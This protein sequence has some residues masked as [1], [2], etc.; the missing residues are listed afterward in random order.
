MKLRS[1]KLECDGG[2]WYLSFSP[3]ARSSRGGL[4]PKLL[5]TAIKSGY[6]PLS[7][8]LMEYALYYEGDQLV[9]SK[10]IYHNEHP[11][12][13][14]IHNFYQLSMTIIQDMCIRLI[15]ELEFKITKEIDFLLNMKDAANV[16]KEMNK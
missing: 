8:L 11:E 9:F 1:Y 16:W 15:E 5:V 12:D 6:R 10:C 2:R 4:K 14:Y 13:S 3:R 7:D